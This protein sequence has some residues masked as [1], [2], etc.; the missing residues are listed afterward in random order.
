MVDVI[1][2]DAV[3]QL[4]TRADDSTPV[5]RAEGQL[6]VQRSEPREF[7][8]NVGARQHAVD[9]GQGEAT[10]QSFEQ[11]ETIRHRERVSAQRNFAA[12]GVIGGQ[13]EQFAVGSRDGSASP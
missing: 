7:L 1:G 3:V 4:P 11:S 8:E 10:D 2:R 6:A 13:D 12:R 9:V 5:D